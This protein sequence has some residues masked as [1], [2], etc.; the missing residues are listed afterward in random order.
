MGKSQRVK[1]A[2][3][4]R[5][6]VNRFK[7]AGFLDATRNYADKVDGLGVDVWAGALDIQVKTYKNYA[8]LSK[9]KEVKSNAGF[10]ALVTKGNNEP[11]MIALKLD[12]F[13]KIVNDISLVWDRSLIPPF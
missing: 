2:Q 13:L 12:D 11:W 10:K 1:G 7:K 8:P 4:E 5:D 6:I 9:Y 3:G